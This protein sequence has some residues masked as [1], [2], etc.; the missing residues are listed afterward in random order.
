MVAKLVLKNQ[1]SQDLMGVCE[2]ERETDRQTGTTCFPS[3][4]TSPWA[5][6]KNNRMRWSSSDLV[7]SVLNC[8]LSKVMLFVCAHTSHHTSALF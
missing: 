7:V 6:S 1:S 8:P 3:D 2:R 4:R 5:F